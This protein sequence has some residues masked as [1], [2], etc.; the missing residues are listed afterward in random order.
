M[1]TFRSKLPVSV[2]TAFQWHTRPGALDRL[3]PPWENVQVEK[4]S[5]SIDPGSQVVLR[6]RVGGFPVRWVAEHTEL[7]PNDCF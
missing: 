4:R 5:D 7:H 2:D 3:I 1:F 6:M